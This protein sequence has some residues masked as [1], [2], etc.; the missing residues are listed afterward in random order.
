[1]ETQNNPTFS[2]PHETQQQCQNP[3]YVKTIE[4][5]FVTC[6]FCKEEFTKLYY[7][8]LCYECDKK[9]KIK[10]EKI[11]F[12]KKSEIANRIFTIDDE[13]K[14]KI[15]NFDSLAEFDWNK[16][17]IRKLKE[18]NKLSK[19]LLIS[20]GYG[21]GKTELMIALIYKNYI[22]MGASFSYFLGLDKITSSTTGDKT[23]KKEEFINNI[24]QKDILIFDDFLRKNETENTLSVLC[25]ILEFR[26]NKNR[27]TIL[28]SNENI[29][30]IENKNTDPK[31]HRL[32]SRL[33]EFEVFNIKGFDLRTQ[34]NKLLVKKYFEKLK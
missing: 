16:E 14:E 21:C 8:Q 34:Q 4:N 6:K 32:F 31:F 27:G 25:D 24:K 29:K 10:I 7:N 12:L 11:E 13:N 17:I 5:N 22:N 20:G 30:T 3:L 26:K 2:H 19:N 9:D 33:S 1:M 18:F 23:N 28:T 15:T